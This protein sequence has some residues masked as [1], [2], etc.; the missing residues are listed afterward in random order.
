MTPLRT[1][2]DELRALSELRAEL[3]A[4]G[5]DRPPP[6][7]WER[8]RG[9]PVTFPNSWRFKPICFAKPRKSPFSTS[10]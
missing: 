6:G 7:C 3:R 9:E 8:C 10:S 4:E 5:L 1:R 2:A